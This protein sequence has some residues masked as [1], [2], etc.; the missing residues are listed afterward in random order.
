VLLRGNRPGALLA[1]DIECAVCGAVTTTPGLA[2]DQVIPFGARMVGRD[3][4]PRPHPLALPAGTVLADRDEL[5]RVDLLSRP[6]DVP[7]VPFDVSAPTLHAAGAEYDALTGGQLAAHR[8]AVPPD[9]DEMW[10]GLT[11]LP[12]VWALERLNAGVSTPGF[13]CLA[14]EPDAVAANQ[15]GAFRE[16]PSVWSQH[17]L[18]PAMAAGAASTGFSTHALAVFAA[19]RA[20]AVG[21]NRVGFSPP[22]RAGARIEEFHIE[23]GS[24]E[25]GPSERLPVLVRRFDRFDWPGGWGAEAAATRAAAIDALIASQPRINA[26]HPGVLVLSVGAVRR[27]IDPVLIEGVTRALQERGR[28]H[29]GLAAVALMLPKIY[30]TA[31]Q[32]QVVFGWI[33]LPFANPHHKSSGVIIAAPPGAAMQGAAMQAAPVV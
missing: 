11:R 5:F 24:G 27:Q 7:A 10:P 29:R 23:I 30:A 8:A 9:T 32:D 12:V 22:V 28:R 4:I 6:R 33:F 19:A 18:F 25:A 1:I 16:F 3:R 13:W 15:L 31:R 21:G 17:P 26:R 20:L 14:R 2:A